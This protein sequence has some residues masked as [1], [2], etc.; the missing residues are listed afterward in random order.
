VRN[1]ENLPKRV[2]IKHGANE[3][4]LQASS[5]HDSEVRKFLD[6]HGHAYQYMQ[7]GVI[8]EVELE[9]LLPKNTTA[10]VL[11]K[12]GLVEVKNCDAALN[13]TATYG[14]ADV[15]VN[16]T[17]TSEVKART[18]FGDIYSNLAASPVENTSGNDFK[19]WQVV[20]YKP[21]TG[22]P[23]FVESKYGKVY[24]RKE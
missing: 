10:T 13:I 6:E 1:K 17:S 16:E 19:N 2:L 15:A 9:V 8:I 7:T 12:Y 3:Y 24:L 22:K 20:V 5:A 4:Y 21:G 23:V 11:A 14:G 18:K